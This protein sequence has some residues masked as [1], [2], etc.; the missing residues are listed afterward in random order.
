MK[1]VGEVMAI[2]RTFQEALGKGIRS[3]ETGRFGLDGN[4]GRRTSPPWRI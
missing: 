1:S 3:L 4:A 2:G